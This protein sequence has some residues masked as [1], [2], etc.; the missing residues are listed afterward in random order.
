M[1]FLW[2]IA[3]NGQSPLIL[4]LHG[5]YCWCFH[6]W[7]SS[8]EMFYC[9]NSFT[10]FKHHRKLD[11]VFQEKSEIIKYP[12]LDE[13]LISELARLSQIPQIFPVG[14]A[15]WCLYLCQAKLNHD[16]SLYRETG[17]DNVLT[18][19]YKLFEISGRKHLGQPL[20]NDLAL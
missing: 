4:Q 14:G 3:S 18:F 20:D 8:T 19:L 1:P 10:L 13:Y 17:V 7:W 12:N 2:H 6:W 9:K 5:A 16:I 11:L 15:S